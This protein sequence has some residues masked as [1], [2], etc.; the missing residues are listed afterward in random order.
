MRG[1]NGTF[2]GLRVVAGFDKQGVG[3]EKRRINLEKAI[4]QH[5]NTERV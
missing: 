5:G 4:L 1:D 3:L 2:F